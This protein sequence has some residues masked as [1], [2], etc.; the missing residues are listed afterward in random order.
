M[1]V[2]TILTLIRLTVSPILLP[3]LIVTCLP[4]DNITLNGM[5]MF[6]FILFALTDFLDGYLARS[7]QKASELGRI[8]D[9]IAD[10]FLVFS[11]LIALVAVH[12]LFFYWAIVLIGR[13]FFVM[14]LREI[15]LEYGFSVRVAL[16]GK[17]KMAVHMLFISFVILNP[18]QALGAQAPIW[19]GI[20]LVLLIGS[21]FLS[22][23]SAFYYYRDF[24]RRL[25]EAKTVSQKN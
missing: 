3:V 9:P 5:V 12:K 1:N 24:S 21:L 14:G 22:I 2:P 18:A 11:T 13:E 17:I 19:N 23:L 4:A 7:R 15:S 20:E 6:V 16:L 25:R 8:L 10:K